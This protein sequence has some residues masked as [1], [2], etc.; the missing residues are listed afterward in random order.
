M[1]THRENAIFRDPSW[2]KYWTEIDVRRLD[3]GLHLGAHHGL[4]RKNYIFK[5]EGSKKLAFF[6]WLIV[7]SSWNFGFQ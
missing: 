3:L 1:T 5:Q 6:Q 4:A 2:R 7:Q